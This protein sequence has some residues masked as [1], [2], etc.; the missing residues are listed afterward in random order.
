VIRS[1][2]RIGTRTAHPA[3]AGLSFG[4]E[5][6]GGDD[7]ANSRQNSINCAYPQATVMGSRQLRSP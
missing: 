4:A 1:Y 5:S 7:G 2:H 3:T 6:S